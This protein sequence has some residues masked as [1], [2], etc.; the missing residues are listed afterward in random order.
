MTQKINY[1][2]IMSDR[3]LFNETV[4][5]PLSEAI[6]ILEERQ[7]DSSLREKVEKIL[8]NNIPEPLKKEGKY[9]VQSRQLAT[10]NHD[11]YWFLEV[12][13]DRGLTPI[14]LEYYEDKL[15]SNNDSKYSLGVLRIHERTNKKGEFIEEKINVVNF[16]KDDGKKIKDIFTISMEPLV[17]FHH[18]LFEVFGFKEGDLYFYDNSDWFKKNGGNAIDYYT[19]FLLLFICHGIFFE[20]YL[21]EGDE[22]EF[23][24]DIL[25]PALEK[26]IEL[27]G[28]KPLI[29]PIPPMDN[30]VDSHWFSYNKN[31]KSNV[32]I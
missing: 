9:G 21:T 6:K 31:I 15:T 28:V 22:G 8:V 5:T 26:A 30:E 25:L 17:D 18:R 2:S 11:T 19:N 24:R 13:K 29:V 7:K 14:F 1:E 16:S 10:P 32:N 4:Y 23:T 20:N 27:S 12:T 3:K